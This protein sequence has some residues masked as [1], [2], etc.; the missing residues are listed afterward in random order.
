MIQASAQ[1]GSPA[2]PESSS[3]QL[4]DKLGNFIIAHSEKTDLVVII[5][6]IFVLWAIFRW[7]SKKG[8]NLVSALR[9]M[10][11]V[12]SIAGGLVTAAVLL[13]LH[14]PDCSKI[15][16]ENQMFAGF[17]ALLAGFAMG[18]K[19]LKESFSSTK[20]TSKDGD[21]KND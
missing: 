10:A 11:G 6:V 16:A 14:Q 9:L 20:P 21:K 1:N 4:L 8:L 3:A 15:S 18:G 17:V 5:V 13:F 19:E 2:P 12:L 7:I